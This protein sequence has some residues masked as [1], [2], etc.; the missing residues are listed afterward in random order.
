MFATLPRQ[1]LTA[2]RGVHELCKHEICELFA[3][4]LRSGFLWDDLIHICLHE[5]CSFEVTA[6]GMNNEGCN[7]IQ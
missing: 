4:I 7:T 6:N 5:R 1:S 3:R 2:A